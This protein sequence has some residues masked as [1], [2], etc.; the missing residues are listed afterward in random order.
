[1]LLRG[2]DLGNRAQVGCAGTKGRDAM[3]TR[4]SFEYRGN[5]RLLFGIIFGVLG[6][7]LF[8]QTTLNIAPTMAADLNVATSMMNIAVSITALFSGIFIVVLG[9]LA[10]RLGRV[11]ILMWGFALGIAGSILVGVAPPGTWAGPL[12]MLGRICQ[13]LSG[14]CIMPA[15]L[16]LVKA[17]WDGAGRQRA[18]SLWSMGS[19]GGSGFAALFG[20]LMAE[21]VGWRYIFFAS[22]L[23]S[24]L[25]MLM[26]RGTPESKAAAEGHFKFDTMG[27]L[28]FMVTMVA[29]L[30]V[31]T[32]GSRIGWT[33]PI[34]LG[35]AA[36][37]LAFGILFLRTESRAPNA[38]VNFK[39]FRNSTYTGAT[40]SN[41]LLN[42][43]AG[44]QLVSMTLVQ[45]GGGLR[46]K[47]RGC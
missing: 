3:T 34:T 5:D 4:T 36:T 39:L 30:V 26:V 20:G 14:A 45:I 23:V 35:L 42:G 11:R 28:T 8:A 27:V 12:L 47:R 1:M 46:H 16:A 19:W 9:G 25:G 17:Y 37:A 43:V 41:L 32:Q 15:S 44:M 22:A 13:G 31:A 33:S 29:L 24:L 10:D 2:D 38:F 21:N 40:L 6:F 7:W 18:V